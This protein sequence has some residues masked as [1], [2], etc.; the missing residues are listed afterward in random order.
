MKRL[1]LT[2]LAVIS[3]MLGVS[4]VVGSRSTPA[5]AETTIPMYGCGGLPFVTYYNGN[6]IGGGTGFN[7]TYSASDA[8]YVV[9]TAAG[10]KSA[11]ASATSGQKVYVQDGATI[12]LDS[13]SNWYTTG[14]GFNV[15][16]GV[17]LVGGR[18]RV[19]NP[20]IIRLGSGFYN[21][22]AYTLIRPGTN[23]KIGGLHIDGPQDGTTGGNK[24]RAMQTSSTDGA[25]NNVEIFNC[26]IHGFGHRALVVYNATNVWMHHCH[27]HHIRQSDAAM[28]V[29]WGSKFSEGKHASATVEGCY[30]DYGTQFIA[31]ARGLASYT[32]R[33][34]Y[35][36]PTWVGKRYDV[37]GQNDGTSYLTKTSSGEWEWP[38]GEIT[39]IYNNTDEAISGGF[40][41]IRGVPS[42]SGRI[43]VY[44]NWTYE[45][46]TRMIGTSADGY[47]PT[48][49]Q[50]MKNIPDYGYN[51]PRDASTQPL[52]WTSPYKPFVRMSVHDNWFGAE[53]PPSTNRAPVLD[54][55]GDKAVVEQTTLSFTIS[56]TDPDGNTLAYSASNLPVGATFD[57]AT[58]TFSWTP[59]EGQAGVYAGI[60]F[61]VSDGSLSDAEDITITVSHRIQ[62]DVNRDG[63][64][65]SLDM[66]RVGQHWNETGEAGWIPEDI[67]KDGVVNVL[68]ATLVGQNWTG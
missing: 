13:T 22:S 65:N 9:S 21:D 8:D 42:L 61:Q 19:S 55:I 43:K 31:S 60:R 25:G 36:G 39:E 6:P 23:S 2:L 34:N 12:T 66:I 29:V 16:N 49:A 62:A 52:S 32:A 58:R 50:V 27:V 54:S 17:Y 14:V 4:A 64:V 30:A 7:P 11:L 15:P 10:L 18:G 67:N 33:Y 38:A 56:A 51:A 26:E 3:L 24:W 48:I 47:F 68:D 59:E 63:A 1:I 53:P 40:C 35:T 46:E 45:A 5:L 37:H 20:G 28:V 41:R 44:N 57:A